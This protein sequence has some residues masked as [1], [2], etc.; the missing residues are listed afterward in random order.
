MASGGCRAALLLATAGLAAVLCCAYFSETF[1]RQT[2]WT[3]R[4]LQGLTGGAQANQFATQA[5]AQAGEFAG[6]VAQQTGN[7]A[8]QLVSQAGAQAGQFVNQAGQVL[9]NP[10]DLTS[11][12]FEYGTNAANQAGAYGNAVGETSNPTTFL[13]EEYR[14]LSYPFLILQ[15]IFAVCYG[16]TVVRNYPFWRGPNPMS[17]ELQAQ[18]APCATCRTSPSNCCLSWCCPQAR[19]AHTFDKTGTLEY[20]CGVIAMFLCPFCTLCW[21]NACTDLN[22]KLGSQAQNPLM[23]AICT[24]LCFCCTI[25]QDAE[26]LDLSTGAQTG[27]CGVRMAGPPQMMMG[28]GYGYGGYY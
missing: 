14:Y 27:P 16:C 17:A 19:A 20:W 28:P 2:L 12:G 24:W 9:R 8:G 23:S 1:R 4:R 18:P 25:A 6:Q 10:S 7:R 15:I 22:P 26:S 21:T 11:H 5:G 3:G 13:P